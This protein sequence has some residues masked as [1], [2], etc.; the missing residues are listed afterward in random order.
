MTDKQA[1]FC[2]LLL[3]FLFCN[4][5]NAVLQIVQHLIVRLLQQAN[6]IVAVNLHLLRKVPLRR[7]VHRMRQCNDRLHHRAKTLGQDRKDEDQEDR[8]G[9]HQ[10][11]RIRNKRL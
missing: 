11:E 3:A 5:C 6:L 7:A 10:A 4:Q 2:L 1:E 9:K 8:Q